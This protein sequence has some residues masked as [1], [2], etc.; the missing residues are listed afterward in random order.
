MKRRLYF[1]LPDVMHTRSI[2]DEL[3]A[4]GIER[5]YIHVIAAQ[6]VDLEGLPVA[7]RNQRNDL[8]AKLETIL[9]NGNLVLFAIALLVLAVLALLQ[10]SWYWLLIPVAIM[11]VTFVTGVE[12][13]RYIPNVH[14]SE[15]TD[16]IHHREILLMVDVPVG[17]VARIEALV[18]RH[19]PEVITGGVGWHVDALHV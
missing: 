7:S 14:L 12:F 3:E 9:W 1:L 2:V 16:A 15:F 10:V 4:V 11:L 6:G 5:R 8:G 13:T 18:H 17:Q 19:H